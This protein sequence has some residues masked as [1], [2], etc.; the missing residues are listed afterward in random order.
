LCCRPG[1][2]FNVCVACKDLKEGDKTY[3]IVV[4]DTVRP[5]LF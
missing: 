5:E 2:V 4:A 1:Y 3:A